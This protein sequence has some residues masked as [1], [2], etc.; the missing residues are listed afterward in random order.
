MH[1]P[2][3]DL[4]GSDH[5]SGHRSCPACRLHLVRQPARR[6]TTRLS[7][8]AS[9]AESAPTGGRATDR[10]WR[11]SARCVGVFL[12]GSVL[13]LLGVAAWLLSALLSAPLMLAGLWVWAREFD[14]AERL[15]SRFHGWAQAL[16]ERVRVKPVRWGLM[17]AAS[18]G[19]TGT[20]YWLVMTGGAVG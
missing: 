17:T 11:S 5:E 10:G 9:P 1:L 15:L 12:L 6:A 2:S 18:L 7:P 13:N 3:R 8:V 19:G 16:W 20:A 4:K 14:W